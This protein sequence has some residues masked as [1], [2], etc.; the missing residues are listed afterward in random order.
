MRPSREGP[1]FAG[2][3][4]NLTCDIELDPAVDL[5]VVDSVRWVIEGQISI[6]PV[7]L[8]RITI[9]ETA[10]QFFPVDISDS[11][12]YR[13]D[14]QYMPSGALVRGQTFD[15]SVEGTYLTII[16]GTYTFSYDNV[17]F[18]ENRLYIISMFF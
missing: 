18:C 7:T 8:D 10:T 2:T 3:A 5:P 1:Y 11:T 14:V 15:L 4:L 12:T 9:T 16:P 17:E 13:C 6:P